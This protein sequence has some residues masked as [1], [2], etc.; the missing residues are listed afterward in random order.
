M[1]VP[2]PLF[3]T[4]NPYLTYS[5]SDCGPVIEYN[6]TVAIV[7]HFKR[8]LERLNA[9]FS[10]FILC[11]IVYIFVIHAHTYCVGGRICCSFVE[12]ILQFTY[13]VY[14]LKGEYRG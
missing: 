5:Y 2:F 7:V 1:F 4:I 14:V 11:S 9:L 13:T 10:V 8:G 6:L 3:H 12:Q